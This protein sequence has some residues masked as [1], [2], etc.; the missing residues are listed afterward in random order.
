VVAGL[1]L[2]ART[3]VHDLSSDAPVKATPGRHGSLLILP[4]SEE[5]PAVR[6]LRVRLVPP[7]TE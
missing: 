7:E 4:A 2:P 6:V 5:P 1:H 3:R